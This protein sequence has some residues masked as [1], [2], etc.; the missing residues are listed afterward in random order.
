MRKA[1]G[2]GRLPGQRAG[3]PRT[4]RRGTHRGRLYLPR[5]FLG[6]VMPFTTQRIAVLTLCILLL[7]AVGMTGARFGAKAP[8]RPIYPSQKHS[9]M[10]LRSPALKNNH[11]MPKIFTADGADISPPLVWHHAPA[12]TK[13]FLVIMF[14]PDAP[15]PMPFLH[16]VVFNIPPAV[17]RLPENLPRSK[18]IAAVAG[19]EQGPNSFGHRGYGG[20]APPPGPAHHYH[21]EIYSLNRRLVSAPNCFRCLQHAIAGH[22]LAAAGLR[23]TYGR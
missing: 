21:I 13:T 16:W 10:T 9:P 3:R 11:V 4:L 22:V 18:R 15:G 7:T 14:D 8:R 5:N 6:E 19:A 1:R 2:N 23:V 20:P 12:K 17:R